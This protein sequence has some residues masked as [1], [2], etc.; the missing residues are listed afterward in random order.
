MDLIVELHDGPEV[1]PSV[2]IPERF[3]SSHTVT[4]VRNAGQAVELPA[5]FEALGHLDQL[6]AV[7]EW[8]SGP[9]PWAVML[10]RGTA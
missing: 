4:M 8:R 6:L 5:L 7:W 2:L 3:K 1:K 9:T 10:A